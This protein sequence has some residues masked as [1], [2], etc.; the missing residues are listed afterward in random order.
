MPKTWRSLPFL[1]FAVLA[2]AVA[3][4]DEELVT[5]RPDQTESPVVVPR[6]TWQLELGLGAGR[7][8]GQDT[9]ESPGTLV[10]YGL[11]ERLEARLA[12]PGWIRNESEADT[13]S[14]LGDPE[15]GVKIGLHTGPDLALLAHC[16]LPWGDDEVG[17]EDP[18]PSLR[19]AG[20][21][22]FSPRIG[23]GWNA[24]L[25]ANSALTEG[26]R[27]RTLSRW[28]YTASLG[29]DLSDTWGTFV[30]AF[31]DAPASDPGPATYSI[32]TGL[33]YLV[34]PRLQLDLAAGAGLDDDAPDWFATAGVSVRLPR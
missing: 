26:G 27:A 12:W 29:I 24:G 8:E 20:A 15:L 19:L 13:A 6:R 16:S 7:D 3:V 30:E 14:G 4:A 32:D 10:R 9:V 22:V 2:A 5:D 1:L 25:A 17:A 23:L 33:T 18:L 31:G 11:F 21:H 28:V 34:H